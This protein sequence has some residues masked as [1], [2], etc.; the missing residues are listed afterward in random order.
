MRKFLLSILLVLIL[1][2]P[3]FS[4]DIV[5][6]SNF[7]LGIDGN[8]DV[9]LEATLEAT[10]LDQGFIVVFIYRPTDQAALKY[11]KK[12]SRGLKPGEI[13]AYT[14]FLKDSPVYQIAKIVFIGNNGHQYTVTEKIQPDKWLP[15]KPNTAVRDTWYLVQEFSLYK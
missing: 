9:Y 10:E 12:E 15:A 14:V 1:A 6:V 2:S 11:F 7:S 4:K 5:R 3:S 8:W 13:H